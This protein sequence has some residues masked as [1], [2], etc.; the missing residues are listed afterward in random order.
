MARQEPSVTG[1]ILFGIISLW[2][3]VTGHYLIKLV[4][5]WD[6]NL[7]DTRLSPQKEIV[8]LLLGM[9]QIQQIGRGNHLTESSSRSG[10][11]SAKILGI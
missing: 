8:I 9:D 2:I 1:K 7:I 3:F 11:L 10:K 5:S 4:L 6:I